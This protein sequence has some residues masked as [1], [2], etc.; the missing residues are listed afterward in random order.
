MQ[1]NNNNNNN[2]NAVVS[3]TVTMPTAK[4]VAL[5]T[6]QAVAKTS[7]RDH[8]L[9]VTKSPT[10]GTP[11][12]LVRREGKVIEVCAN[13]KRA[14]AFVDRHYGKV[15]RDR[16][17]AESMD[18]SQRVLEEGRALDLQHAMMSR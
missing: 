10:T 15:R 8:E 6:Q 3:A 1:N 18:D 9:E 17:A 14:K 13:P 16:E 12:V 7:Y 5:A 2:N 4:D 11:L